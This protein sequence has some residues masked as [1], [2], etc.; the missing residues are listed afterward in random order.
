MLRTAS[1]VLRVLTGLAL[2]CALVIRIRVAATAPGIQPSGRHFRLAGWNEPVH[3]DGW[4]WGWGWGP[5]MPVHD[6]ETIRKT[7]TLSGAHRSLD[8]DNVFGSIDVAGTDGDQVQLVVNKT[9]RAESKEELER[10]R[11]NITLDI[12]QDGNSLRLYVNGPFRRHDDDFWGFHRDDGYFADMDFQLQVPRDT[13]LTLK[14]VGGGEVSVR[15]V[16][17]T[18]EIHNVSGSVEMENIAGSGTAQTVNGGVKV[19]FRE[20]PRESCDFGSINGSVELFFAPKLSADFQLKTFNGA[21]YSDFPI[22]ETPVNSAQEEHEGLK[23]IFRASRFTG[24]R[25][26]A[27]GPEITVKNLNGD[28]RILENH[29]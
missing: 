9:L 28:I 8:V 26:G 20:N 12:T 29:E 14:T 7:F 2:L 11:K 3:A 21:V 19:K 25:V 23:T 13:D 15:N 10:A 5:D 16:N 1:I 17:G 4:D 24:G 27:G 22:T 18:F 6:Q